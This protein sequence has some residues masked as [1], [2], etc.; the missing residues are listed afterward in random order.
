VVELFNYIHIGSEHCEELVMMD[1]SMVL[2]LLMKRKIKKVHMEE[3]YC[4]LSYSIV[5][6][7]KLG[8]FG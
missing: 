3:L 2:S 8:K 4:A 6:I 1:P 5:M 7:L